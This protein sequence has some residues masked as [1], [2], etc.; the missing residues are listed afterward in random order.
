MISIFF[1][2]SDCIAMLW[3]LCPGT[4][5]FQEGSNLREGLR[6]GPTFWAAATRSA[7][8]PKRRRSSEKRLNEAMLMNSS[9]PRRTHSS[10]L[11]S[12]VYT[13]ISTQGTAARSCIGMGSAGL[14]ART[15]HIG[16]LARINFVVQQQLQHMSGRICLACGIVDKLYSV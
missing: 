15:Y 5:W 9:V 16:Q 2:A 6:K 11:D 7:G 13:Y 12:G 4:T 14:G 8:A 1:M 10:D 3:V